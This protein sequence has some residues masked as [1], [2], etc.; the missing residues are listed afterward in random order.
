MTESQDAPLIYFISGMWCS[1]CAKTI[2]DGASKITGIASAE[3]SYPSKLL[4]VG[5]RDQ[6]DPVAADEEIRKKV[7]AI[8]FGIKKQS[9]GWLQSFNEDLDREQKR[10]L[11]TVRMSLVWFLAMWSSMIAFAGYL[12]GGISTDERYYFSLASSVFGIPAI[13]IGIIPYAQSGWRALSSSRLWTLDLFISVGGVAAVS[14]TALNLLS[15]QA[16]SYADSGAMIV[17]ILLLTKFIES[18]VAQK[19]SSSILFQINQFHDFTEVFK[20]GDWKKAQA[21]QIRKEDRVRV[22]RG[23]TVAFDGRLLSSSALLNS[24]LLSG[25][26]ALL[27]LSEG[28]HVLAGTIA[29]SDFEMIVAQPLGYRRIDTWAES[30][31]A[32]GGGSLSGSKRFLR[33][34]SSLTAVAFSGAI[35]VSA[36]QW[37][38]GGTPIET[39]EA[40]FTGILIFCP[41]LFAS[42]IPI[43][44]QMVHLTLLKMGVIINRTEALLD[45]KKIKNVY[46]DKTGTLE[47]A[48]SELICLD[49]QNTDRI[50]IILHQLSLKSHHPILRG[51]PQLT[52]QTAAAAPPVLS[53]IQEFPGQGVTATVDGLSPLVVG[54]FEF[55]NERTGVAQVP[56]PYPVIALNGQTAGHIVVKT[57]FNHQAKNFLGELLNE[58]P[59][60]EIEILSGDPR[61]EA[62]APLLMIAPKRLIYRGGLSPEEKAQAILPHSLYIGDGLND[63]LALAKASVSC[64]V[65]NRVLG[66]APVDIQLQVPDLEIILSVMKY[67]KRY[68]RILLQTALS[69]LL[70]N[71]IAFSLAIAGKFSP[72]GAV[73]AM[74]LSFVLLFLSSSR[75]LLPIRRSHAAV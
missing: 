2:Q 1:T 17:A 6:A 13:I 10:G 41:C 57:I 24:H 51:L 26:D 71:V 70:Y 65:G 28:D 50:Q 20:A 69:A 59:R 4:L 60:A 3:V 43:S 23:T 39:A 11:S 18:S 33:L 9:A 48:E 30:A 53:E 15:G 55:V 62:G 45:L 32:S 56:S 68:R 12:G 25:E 67:A 27:P 22:A 40:F 63:T 34:E 73:V 66:F 75:L 58:L 47:A 5:L 19:L 35:V 61:L 36:A 52:G 72:L 16:H 21:S 31:L 8:G 42:I 49:R 14:L 7:E 37:W 74:L 54:R 44:K 38:R 29:H 64:R 46:L